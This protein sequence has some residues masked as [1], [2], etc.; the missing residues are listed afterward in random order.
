[1][2]TMLPVLM[3]IKIQAATLCLWALTSS[4]GLLQSKKLYLVPLLIE[5]KY[6]VVANGAAELS[7]IG[8]LLRELNIATNSIPC[9]YY[10]NISASYMT[11][12]PV[13]HGRTKHIEIDFHFVREKVFHKTLTMLYTPSVDQLAD[14]LTKALPVQRFLH[15]RNKLT[16]LTRPLSLRG[17]DK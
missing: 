10:D 17:T 7:W 4:Y 8:S 6:K 1:M 14:C 12:N 13:F 5:S 2:L 3:I 9:L 16:V 11:H 15:F